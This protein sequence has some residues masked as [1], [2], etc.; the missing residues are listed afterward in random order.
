MNGESEILD[1]QSENAEQTASEAAGGVQ[2]ATSTLPEDA[3]I[4][5]PMRNT[6]LFPGVVMPVTLGR[7][8]SIA[9]AQEAVRSDLCAKTIST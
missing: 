2:D 6:V 4:L 3:L 7:E 5:V 1:P 9:A 8:R